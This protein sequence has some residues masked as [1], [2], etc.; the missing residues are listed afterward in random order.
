MEQ[1]EEVGVGGSGSINIGDLE[2]VDRGELRLT[3][4]RRGGRDWAQKKTKTS[5]ISGWG[6]LELSDSDELF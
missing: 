3:R 1:A 4:I 5:R 6:S 2:L